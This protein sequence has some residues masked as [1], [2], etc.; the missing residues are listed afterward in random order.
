MVKAQQQ[1]QPSASQH[2][3]TE[4]MKFRVFQSIANSL[5]LSFSSSIRYGSFNELSATVFTWLEEYCKP[6][7]L[8]SLAL[9][10]LYRLPNPF[11]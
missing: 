3:V 11:S 2:Q 9:S 8:Q 7:V 6:Q 4:E 1:Q 10:I 5:F